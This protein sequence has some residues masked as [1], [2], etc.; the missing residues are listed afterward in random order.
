MRSLLTNSL[1][2]LR[3]SCCFRLSIVEFLLKPNDSISNRVDHLPL[4]RPD[5]DVGREETDPSEAEL[6]VFD[7]LTAPSL[8]EGDE[9][10]PVFVDVGGVRLESHWES[11]V[12]QMQFSSE[13]APHIGHPASPMPSSSAARV[14]SS[15]MTF[16]QRAMIE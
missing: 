9:F 8:K 11:S 3:I 14:P 12:S 15:L 1:A 7:A 10:L 6:E 2:S 16:R 13:A 5:V 4:T